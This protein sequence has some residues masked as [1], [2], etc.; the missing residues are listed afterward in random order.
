[1]N[2]DMARNLPVE[3]STVSGLGT[4]RPS[5]YQS[6]TGADQ[7]GDGGKALPAIE[8][9]RSQVEV[10]EMNVEGKNVVDFTER[11]LKAKASKDPY[12]EKIPFFGDAY[13]L[14]VPV[15]QRWREMGLSTD[16]ISRMFAALG[17]AVFEEDLG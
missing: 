14:L 7:F 6:A 16:D 4:A 1:M 11:L 2:V 8:I 9:G 5:V 3:A 13:R 17:A 12:F 15:V 10:G